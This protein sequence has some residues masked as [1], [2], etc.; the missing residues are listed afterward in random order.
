MSNYLAVA[1]VTETLRHLVLQAVQAIPGTDVTT[2]RPE[3]G[4]GGDEARPRVNVFLYMAMPN[5][6]LRNAD[7]PMRN[8]EGQLASRPVAPLD[9]YYLVTFYGSTKQQ[10]AQQLMALT[11]LALHERAVL[12]RDDVLQ[13]IA[14]A[15]EGYLDG[16][17]LPDQPQRVYLS[18]LPHTLEEL[19]KLWSILFQVPYNLS[20][21]LQAS[22]VLLDGPPAPQAL[23]VRQPPSISAAPGRAPVLQAVAAA[24][25]GEPIVACCRVEVLGTALDGVEVRVDG[26]PAPVDE[27]S[28]ERLVVRLDGPHLHAG[29]MEMR[30]HRGD[31]ASNELPFVLAPLVRGA[32]VVPAPPGRGRG[33]GGHAV[34]VDVEPWVP[35]TAPV[36][37][38]LDADDG[39]GRRYAFDAPEVLPVPVHPLRQGQFTVPV[40]GVAPG[41]YVVRVQVGGAV[42]PVH[43]T[44]LPASGGPVDAPRVVLP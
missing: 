10:V 44:R 16:S 40:Q 6:S 34:R 41:R 22:V 18:P 37:L 24:E 4:A 31:V 35:E 5:P 32:A 29:R 15:P 36:T 3:R 25:P 13:A 17:D 1:T 38:L 30:A 39:S 43:A 14:S 2:E 33:R 19:S 42:S 11:A 27:R 12:T 7:L 28:P 20:M 9:L 21:A 8:A 26:V 23:P